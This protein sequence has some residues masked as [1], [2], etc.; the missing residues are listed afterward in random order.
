M[1]KR[2]IALWSSRRT[3]ANASRQSSKREFTTH[4]WP[5]VQRMSLY[6]SYLLDDT[7]CPD[8]NLVIKI[9]VISSTAIR[10]NE[11]RNGSLRE[12]IDRR[13]EQD[14]ERNKES[15]RSRDKQHEIVGI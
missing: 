2:E 13:R 15:E 4:V 14:Y 6:L 8:G 12:D 11:D 3:R 7:L 10:M 1:T 9:L 5:W